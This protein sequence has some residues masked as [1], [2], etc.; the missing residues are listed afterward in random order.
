[1]KVRDDEVTVNEEQKQCIIGTAG[2]TIK[3]VKMVSIR[4]EKMR[5]MGFLGA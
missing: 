1:M 3:N 4:K 5:M 2:N